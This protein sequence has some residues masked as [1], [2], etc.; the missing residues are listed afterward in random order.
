MRQA[1]ADGLLAAAHDVSDGGL[2]V[3][4]TEMTL[5]HGI[6]MTIDSDIDTN[7]AA[8]WF[9]EDQARYVLAVADEHVA[10]FEALMS[11][12]EMTQLGKSIDGQ[13]TI[14]ASVSIS[15]TELRD[16]HEG[17]LPALMSR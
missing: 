3:A 15:V 5:A 6:G 12:G 13:L 14:G 8:F 9:G 2:L 10:A 1:I 17:W 16:I 4:L 7:N 11:D